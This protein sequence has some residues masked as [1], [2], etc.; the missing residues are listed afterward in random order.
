M[1]VNA[2]LAISLSK[3]EKTGVIDPGTQNEARRKGL[4][5]PS[6]TEGNGL[7]LTPKG[8]KFLHKWGGV[9]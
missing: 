9:S 6:T 2:E 3:F 5:A 1:H 8:Q 4:I 7:V